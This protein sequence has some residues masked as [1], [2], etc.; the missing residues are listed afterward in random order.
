MFSC[1]LTNLSHQHAHFTTTTNKTKQTQQKTNFQKMTKIS[2]FREIFGVFG[3]D[4]ICGLKT[5][6]EVFFG[7][8]EIKKW[9][10]NKKV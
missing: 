1:L 5:K 8:A 2:E 6:V 7:R 4:K 3:D 10:G 9:N